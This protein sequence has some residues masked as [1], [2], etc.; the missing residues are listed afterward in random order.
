MYVVA[1]GGDVIGLRTN[2]RRDTVFMY[3]VRAAR[4]CARCSSICWSAPINSRPNRSSTTRSPTI[5]PPVVRHV[6]A[7]ARRIPFSYEVILPAYDVGADFPRAI[8]RHI[9]LP[10]ALTQ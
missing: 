8:R 7:I 3:P 10:A 5:A 6:N 1:D 2:H 4:K 9:G